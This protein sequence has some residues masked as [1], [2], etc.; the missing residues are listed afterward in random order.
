MYRRY[1][2]LALLLASMVMLPTTTTSVSVQFNSDF[3]TTL[4]ETKL[5]MEIASDEGQGVSAILEFK[6]QLSPSETQTAEGLGVDFVRRG[7]SIVHVGRIYS[8]LVHDVDSIRQLSELGLLRAT[9]GSKQYIPSLTSSIPAINA[10]D[11]WSNLQT[12]GQTVDGSGVSV[13]VIDTGAAWLHPSFWKQFPAEFDFISS[14]PDYYVD[15]NDN[16]IADPDEGPVLTVVGQSGPLIAYGADYMYISSD[17]TGEFD[18]ADGDRWIGGIDSNDD[19]NIDL[20]SEK[21]VILNISKVAILYDQFTSDV[22]VRGVNLTQ[23]VSVADSHSSYHGTHVSSTVAGGQPGFTSYVGAAPG[24][25]LI[26][27][28]SPL[29]SADILDGISFAVE[30]EADIINMS[31]SSYLGF[32]D[33]TDPEDL[34]VTEAFLNHGVL[35]TAAAGN[36]GTRNK[37]ARFE[38]GTGENGTVVLQ[39]SNPPDGS[40]LSLLWQS[41]DRDESVTLIPPSGPDI[42]LG[43]FSEI[44]GSAFALTTD[45][46]N[47]YVFPETSPRGMNNIIIQISES[48]HDW[49]DGDWDVTVTNSGGD[50]IW[51]DGYAWDGSWESTRMRFGSQTSNLYTISS[52]GTS[53][54]AIAVSSYSESG[55][56]ISSTSSRGPRIDG[57]PKPNIAAPGISIRAASGS[58]LADDTLWR[59]KDGTSMASPHVAGVLALIRQADGNDNPWLEYSALANGAEV[60]HS[61]IPSVDWGHGLCDAASSVMYLLDEALN[62]DSTI[63]DWSLLSS[64]ATDLDEPS[65]LPDLDIRNVKMLQK[66]EAIA[67]AVY[68]DDESNFTET[69]MLSV[70]WDTD[71]N[72]LTGRRGADILVNLTANSLTIFEW[73]G[74]AYALSPY[75]GYWWQS[76]IATFI[77]IDGLANGTRGDL[78]FSTHN[79]T[80]T[81]IDS[82]PS[83]SNTNQWRPMAETVDLVI[84][85][86]D[87]TIRLESYDRDSALNSRS[88]GASIVDGDLSILQTSIVSTQ[89]IL[90]MA[91]D[92]TH[93]VSQYVNS[94]E[95]NITSDGET[96]HLPLVMLSAISTNMVRISEASLD[97]SIIRTGFLFTETITGQFTVEGHE[98]ISQALVGFKYSTGL[99]F[100]F[101]VNGD[102]LYEFVVAPSGFPAG[103]YEVFAMV[104]G[105]NVPL[106]EMQFATLTIIEDNT[107][108]VV[109]VGI[110][111]VALIAIYAYRR[112]SDRRGI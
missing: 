3:D 50:A 95:F 47:A 55:G 92:S 60:S 59:S 52:P 54:F 105:L 93:V 13:A 1:L 106:T 69:D 45:E 48:N 111:V 24:A 22:Y 5:K 70:E 7:S 99:W 101:T 72:P 76:S 33:G 61:E 38:V 73:T 74:S 84:S 89:N 83:T 31:F 56:S 6:E 108:I 46:L 57:A 37:H 85:E 44:T 8:A 28:R 16:A 68:T 88:I 90:E 10:D 91:V 96:L 75:T 63:S 79:S 62:T 2:V 109:G 27:I 40:F 112:F 102:G 12:D 94:L 17:G 110:A 67:F 49:L 15:L 41:D 4:I 77:K 103:E 107:L 104:Y 9:S 30:N 82:T 65:V 100:N 32:L 86:E 51:V 14:G 36:L 97:S 58:F 80:L 71:T 39:V 34:A 98:L 18:Y 64:I 78:V 87:M 19:S 42:E 66:E 23:A 21:A 20:N 35:T 25:D 43:V 29:Q 81:Y 26:I 53:D 11:V